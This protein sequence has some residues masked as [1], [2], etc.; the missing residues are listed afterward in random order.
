MTVDLDTA[1]FEEIF[2][3]E[4]SSELKWEQ[5]EACDCY[6]EDSGQ[7]QWGH[8]RCG[9]T[10]ILYAEPIVIRALL[11][12]QSRWLSFR[13]EGE[14]SHGE[15]E[16][17]TPLSVKPGYVNRRVRDRFT[18]LPAQGDSTEGRVYVPSTQPRPFIFGNVQRAWRVTLEAL[19]E[20]NRLVTPNT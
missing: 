12:S 2:A 17:R 20:T 1:I 3:A 10:G 16:L 6:S 9:G 7:P 14:V 19:D 18:M 4:G 8:E 15:I 11:Y 13:R 5:A